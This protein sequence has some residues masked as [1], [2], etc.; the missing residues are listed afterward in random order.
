L[1]LRIGLRQIDSFREEWG[2]AMMTARAAGRFTGIEEL[3]RRARLPRRALRLLADA[4]AFRSIGMDRRQALWEA[5]RTPAGEL[6]LFAAARAR[7]LG[8][9]PDAMLPTMPLSE[10]VA[11][12][13]QLTRLSLKGHPME[14]LRDVFRSEGV[15]SCKQ[16]SEAKDGRRVKVAGVVLV[17]QRPGEGKAIFITLEDETGITNVLLWARTF[18]AQR[19]QVMAAR[20]MLVEGEIQRSEEGVVHLMGEI[21]QDR[22][23]ELQRLSEDHR[24]EI[25]LARADEFEHPQIPRDHAPR[26]SRHPR[27][28]RI[29][30]KSRDFH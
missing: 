6:P 8:E 27:N 29:L 20:L 2:R 22:T 24:T 26:G 16:A 23:T 3:A 15:L 14:F 4:D 13:Y 9:E 5:R 12:D 11:A 17:R 7:E 19:R 30:P 1:A 21:V 18:E 28:V 25:D 10:H